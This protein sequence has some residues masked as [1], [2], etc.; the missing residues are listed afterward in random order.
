MGCLN[1]Q[2]H[3]YSYFNTKII[4]T[5]LNINGP[6]LQEGPQQSSTHNSSKRCHPDASLLPYEVQ[7]NVVHEQF[8]F[9]NTFQK[10]ATI[11]ECLEGENWSNLV[12]MVNSRNLSSETESSQALSATRVCLLLANNRRPF[13]RTPT[14]LDYIGLEG[15]YLVDGRLPI[16]SNEWCFR[17]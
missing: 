8:L 10:D 13:N 7:R 4:P 1:V 14:P 2:N 3:K 17:P 9:S 16:T 15:N 12:S 11:D 5:V 6:S